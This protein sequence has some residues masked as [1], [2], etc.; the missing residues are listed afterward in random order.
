MI[1]NVSKVCSCGKGYRSH[2][3]LRCGHC[4]G[5]AGEQRLRQ[6]HEKLLQAEREIQMQF[7]G[8]YVPEGQPWD[9]SLDVEVEHG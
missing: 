7:Y 9:G 2:Y 1:K 6:F 4:R 8:F 5:E 3:D